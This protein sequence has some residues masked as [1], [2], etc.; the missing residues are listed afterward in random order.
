[1][2][3]KTCNNK[4]PL[5]FTQGL[6]RNFPTC[7]SCSQQKIITTYCCYLCNYDLCANCYSNPYS[8]VQNTSNTNSYLNYQ[9]LIVGNNKLC[10]NGHTLAYSS[11]QQRFFPNCKKCGSQKLQFSYFLLQLQL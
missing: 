5:L 7:N 6:N 1:M 9:P 3:P 2:N 10:N 11:G 8:G 4:H